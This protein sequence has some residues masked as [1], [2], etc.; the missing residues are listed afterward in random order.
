VIWNGKIGEYG[1]PSPAP[2]G[3]NGDPDILI[4]IGDTLVVLEL[5]TIKSK[6][7]QW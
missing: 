3:P 7:Q 5:T 6:S 1:I 2:G 4:F